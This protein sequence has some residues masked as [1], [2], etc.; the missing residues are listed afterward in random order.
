MKHKLELKVQKRFLLVLFA[1]LVTAF[2][3]LQGFYDWHLHKVNQT[4]LAGQLIITSLID[5][6]VNDL[7]AP[8]PIDAQT[9]QVYFPDL[10]LML[11]VPGQNYGLRQAEDMSTP[12]AGHGLPFMQVTTKVIVNQ[13][14]NKLLTAQGDAQNAHKDSQA[15]LSAIVRQV[16]SLE[17]CARG[18]EL[19]YSPQNNS[20][21]KLQ[22]SK[23]L[24]SGKT[25][26]A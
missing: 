10:K 7:I 1:V 6:A 26:Y 14:E 25:L 12:N 20:G 19:F 17:A 2:A 15:Q 13:A 5:N 3:V 24:T 21:Y 23:P 11:P 4:S 16:P 22:F 18:V 9:G 8:A